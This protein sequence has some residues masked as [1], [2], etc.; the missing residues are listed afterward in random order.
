MSITRI[1]QILAVAGLL[2][3]YSAW[4]LAGRE[5]EA[6][7]PPPGANKIRLVRLA[8]AEALW[9]GGTTVF[10]DVRPAAEYDL[11]HVRGAVSF[12]E[13]EFEELFPRLFPET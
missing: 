12:P 8:E 4:V 13:E 5:G 11:G 6:D 9:H 10:L 1:L 3:G 7:Q 2:S